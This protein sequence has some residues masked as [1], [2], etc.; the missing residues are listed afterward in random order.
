M[1]IFFQNVYFYALLPNPMAF[2]G[3]AFGRFTLGHGVRAFKRRKRE[4]PL[5]PCACTK[6]R[7]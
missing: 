4:I 1:L 5:L 6:E 3:G 7:P 2:E